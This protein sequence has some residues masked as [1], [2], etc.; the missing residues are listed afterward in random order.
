LWLGVG[1]V[2]TALSRLAHTRVTPTVR[3]TLRAGRRLRLKAKLHNVLLIVATLFV[4][5]ILDRFT[6]Y[7]AYTYMKGEQ[8]ISFLWNSIIISYV[9]N[10]GAFLGLG[11]NW[12][13]YIKYV[14]LLILPIIICIIVII[15]SLIKDFNR[16]KKIVIISIVAGGLSN[17]FDRLF[18]NFSVIDF[19]NFGIGRIRTGVLNVADLSVTFGVILLFIIEFRIGKRKEINSN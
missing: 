7:L 6:K 11:S 4:N 5:I 14:V 12:N 10:T 3:R 1:S 13:I 16:I 17:L 18:N 9:E 8:S 2:K 15:Y 19:M